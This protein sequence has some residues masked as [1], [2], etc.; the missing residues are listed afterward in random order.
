MESLVQ[1][2]YT[3]QSYSELSLKGHSQEQAAK[4]WIDDM[5]REPQLEVLPISSALR[6]FHSTDVIKPVVTVVT[7]EFSP[8]EHCLSLKSSSNP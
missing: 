8:F 7:R 3:E 2:D 4:D 1:F 6:K 5:L